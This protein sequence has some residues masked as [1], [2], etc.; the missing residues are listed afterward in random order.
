MNG[1]SAA[2]ISRRTRDFTDVL[3]GTQLVN[4]YTGASYNNNHI[5]VDVVTPV[6]PLTAQVGDL[7]LVIPGQGDTFVNAQLYIGTSL[8]PFASGAVPQWQQAQLG[9]ILP[10]GSSV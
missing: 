6:V 8:S 4:P 5:P 10:G 2:G 3:P 1:R 9:P 7:Y